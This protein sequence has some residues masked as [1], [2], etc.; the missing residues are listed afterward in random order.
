[1]DAFY[2]LDETFAL[3][4]RALVLGQDFVQSREEPTNDDR[5]GA[6]FSLRPV[7]DWI[8][9]PTRRLSAGVELRRSGAEAEWERFVDV[10]PFVSVS[11]LFPSPFAGTAP[12]IASGIASYRYRPYDEP[13]PAISLSEEQV[14]HRFDIRLTLEIPVYGDAALVAQAGYARNFSNY[15]IEDFDNLFGSLGVQYRF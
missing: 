15:E 3:R 7:I 4:G 9:T 8:P 11:E 5:D 14:D 13:D 2:L 12:W 10:S 1:V 6:A